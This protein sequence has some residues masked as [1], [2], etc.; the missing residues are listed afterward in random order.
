MN[1]DLAHHLF[2]YRDGVLYWKNP[3]N[4]KKTPCGSVAG[5]ISPRGYVHIQYKRKLYKAHRVIFL[6]FNGYVA[7][8]IDHIDGNT[9]NNRPENLRAATH[10]GNARNAK[11]R[12]DNKSGHKNVFWNKS[13]NKWAVSLSVNNKLRHFGYFEDLEL[14]AFVASEARD[15][16]HGEFARTA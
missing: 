6:M 5:T 16:Y 3:S 7:D 13:A 12:K 1:A 15:K 9:S 8:I 11:K 10:L 2:E 4:P 14:A